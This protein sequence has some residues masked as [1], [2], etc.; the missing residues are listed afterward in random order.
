M[1]VWVWDCPE[2]FDPYKPNFLAA[3]ALVFFEK[4]AWARYWEYFQYDPR[5][6]EET[7]NFIYETPRLTSFEEN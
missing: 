2:W 5:R 6:P 1:K 3:W 4:R 7:S